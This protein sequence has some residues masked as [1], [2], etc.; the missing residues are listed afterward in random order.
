MCSPL[1]A[2]CARPIAEVRGA[3]ARV[4]DGTLVQRRGTPVPAP[5]DGPTPGLLHR[6]TT[7]YRGVFDTSADIPYKRV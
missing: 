5:T 2:A 7:L 4:V 6:T 3:R 1:G